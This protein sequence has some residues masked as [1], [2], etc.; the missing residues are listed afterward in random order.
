MIDG[1]EDVTNGKIFKDDATWWEAWR[2]RVRSEAL[3]KLPNPP[4]PRTRKRR[5]VVKD[6]AAEQPNGVTGDVPMTVDDFDEDE[7]LMHEEMRILIK[8]RSR[9][10]FVARGYSVDHRVPYPALAPRAARYHRWLVQA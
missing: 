9:T 3:Y 1:S 7:N 6:E 8:V 2:K 5:K 10:S 4:D